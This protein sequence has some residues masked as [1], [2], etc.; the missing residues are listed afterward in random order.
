VFLSC[1]FSRG[2]DEYLGMYWKKMEE[3]EKETKKMMMDLV[4]YFLNKF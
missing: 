3:E 2:L 1:Y 4:F